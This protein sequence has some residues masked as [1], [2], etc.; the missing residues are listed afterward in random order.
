MSRRGNPIERRHAQVSA[1]RR[2]AVAGRG[3]SLIVGTTLWDMQDNELEK[4][5]RKFP[6]W[7]YRPY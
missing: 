1:G 2:E 7:R 3:I 5:L 6:H 4:I